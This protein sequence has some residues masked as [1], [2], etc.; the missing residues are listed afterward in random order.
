[1]KYYELMS[2]VPG[3]LTETEVEAAGER[4]SGL[5]KTN[6]GEIVRTQNAG[7][8]KLAYPIDE[9]RYGFYIITVFQAEP[10]QVKAVKKFLKLSDD[11]IRA[12]IVET[13]NIT[14]RRPIQLVAYQEPV[15][16]HDRDREEPRYRS[17]R[18]APVTPTVAAPVA[19]PISSEELE[20]QIDKILDEKVL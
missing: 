13:T 10:S 20:R 11:V 9:H 5:I 12:E 15:V 18:S 4:I 16:D 1:M 6:L 8:I 17:T 2:L 14:P 19:K 3:T 7:K